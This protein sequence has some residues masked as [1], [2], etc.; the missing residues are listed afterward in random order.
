MRIL[1]RNSVS[2]RHLALTLKAFWPNTRVE[3]KE[4]GVVSRRDLK[5]IAESWEGGGRRKSRPS[6]PKEGG[7]MKNVVAVVINISLLSFFVSIVGRRSGYLLLL[8]LRE[9]RKLDGMRVRRW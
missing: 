9:H 8:G 5:E 7:L 4:K 2:L 6:F 3:Y 1:M